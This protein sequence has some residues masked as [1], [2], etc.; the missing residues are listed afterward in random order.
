MKLLATIL[1]SITLFSGMVLLWR[2]LNPLVR[3]ERE[4]AAL[5]EQ[6]RAQLA[7]ERERLALEREQQ[8]ES[9]YDVLGFVY[10]LVP[11]GVAPLAL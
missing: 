2:S 1:L 4:H 11:L 5:I 10:A 6:Q 3:R 9:A 8:A 7:L